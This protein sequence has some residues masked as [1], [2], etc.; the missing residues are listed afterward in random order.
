MNPHPPLTEHYS[1]NDGKPA[2]VNQLFDAGSKHYDFVSNW[3]FLHSGSFYCRWTLRRHG[4]RRGDQLLDVACGTGQVSVAAARILGSAESITCLD[5]SEG[6]LS[7]AKRKLRA[8]FVVGRA[9]RLPFPDNSFDFLTM[10]YALRHVTGLEEAFREYLR[11]LKPG[12][13]VLIL[14]ITKPSGRVG[15]FLF[16]LYFGRIYPFLTRVFTR[17]REAQAMMV[18]YW[19][20]MDACV[21]PE[22]VLGALQS[23]GFADVNR[24]AMLGLF[25]EYTAV[26]GRPVT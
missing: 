7:V 17:S 3:G 6:M 24:V 26:K 20:T 25:S 23:V 19:E 4:L 12:G 13:R 1:G 21:R 8:R 14:E 22:S 5:P 16:K 9:E 10:G 11:V 15:A 2:F 18:Y